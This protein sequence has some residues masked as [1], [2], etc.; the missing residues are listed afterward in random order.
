MKFSFLQQKAI[1]QCLN[2]AREKNNNKHLCTKSAGC[3]ITRDGWV[4][5]KQQFNS[6]TKFKYIQFKLA[7]S[8]NMF[9]LIEKQ[10][11][12]LSKLTSNVKQHFNENEHF[13]KGIKSLAYQRIKGF[14]KSAW[15]LRGKKQQQLKRDKT[16]DITRL[17]INN[18]AY[19]RNDLSESSQ[20]AIHSFIHSFAL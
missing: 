1:F 18:I 8:K 6:H 16:L 15:K 20:L 17:I 5:F 19:N 11:K 9:L 7:L 14:V 12:H 4:R 2:V 10:H 13:K 3:S